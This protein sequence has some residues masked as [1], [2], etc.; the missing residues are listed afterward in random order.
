MFAGVF[1]YCIYCMFVVFLLIVVFVFW[2]ERGIFWEWLCV[3]VDKYVYIINLEVC[4]KFLMNF[5]V[6][7]VV[8][9]LVVGGVYVGSL[10]KVVVF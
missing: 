7:V 9:V 6:L 5:F 1:D 10:I 8:F 2:G 3:Y 4:V